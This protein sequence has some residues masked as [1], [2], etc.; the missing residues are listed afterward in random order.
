MPR[1][2]KSENGQEA[3]DPPAVPDALMP[4]QFFHLSSPSRL[5]GE[6][7][8]ARRVLETAYVDFF[9]GLVVDSDTAAERY[10][11]ARS[12]FL[13]SDVAWPHSF[14][15]ICDVLGVESSCLRKRLKQLRGEILALPKPPPPLRQHRTGTRKDCRISTR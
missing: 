5:F 15:R 8:L 3:L 4:A 14:E 12:W 1:R 2:R 6:A 9:N 11:Q 13:S 7:A 10:A